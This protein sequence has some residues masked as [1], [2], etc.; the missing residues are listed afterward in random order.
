MKARNLIA[1]AL[2]AA[3]G[4]LQTARAEGA[5]TWTFTYNTSTKTATLTKVTAAEGEE[6]PAELSLPSSVNGY[7]VTAVGNN[8]F[9]GLAITSLT[10]PNTVTTIGYGAFAN[11]TALESVVFPDSLKTIEGPGNSAYKG[12][13]NGCT[14]LKSVKFGSGLVTIGSG[15]SSA[16]TDNPDYYAYTGAFG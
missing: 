11:C 5:P 7:T 15:N 12:A 6:I 10:I 8:S 3:L 13:F 4:S 1:A 16:R 2:F 9:Q 14:A